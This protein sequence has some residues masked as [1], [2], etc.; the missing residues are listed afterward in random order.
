[1]IRK[2]HKRKERKAGVGTRV[3]EQQML[4]NEVLT[5]Q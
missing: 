4:G 2:I 5:D 3:K 1:M